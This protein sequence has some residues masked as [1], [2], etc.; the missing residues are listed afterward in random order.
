MEELERK[1]KKAALV[2]P[3]PELDRAVER[4]LLDASMRRRSWFAAPVALWQCALACAVS[5][6]LGGAL[7]A[8]VVGHTAGPK[9]VVRT[10]YFIPTGDALR[11]V[12]DVKSKESAIPTDPSQ[13]RV[14]V[15]PASAEVSIGMGPA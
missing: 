4:M 14:R 12:M 7:Y 3:S 15:E 2:E 13:W 6:L 5:L 1:L 10:V 9:E 8:G 11:D